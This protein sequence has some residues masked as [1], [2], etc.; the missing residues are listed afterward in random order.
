VA[1]RARVINSLFDRKLCLCPCVAFLINSYACVPVWHLEPG[2]LC[3][4]L[5]DF[6]GGRIVPGLIQ[7]GTK[8][9]V[10]HLLQTG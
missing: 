10:R 3:C 7:F 2:G 9:R 8:L 4:V 1:F 6:D 5:V